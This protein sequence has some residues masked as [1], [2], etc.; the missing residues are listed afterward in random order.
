[1]TFSTDL[2]QKIAANSASF[3]NSCQF[4]PIGADI[5]NG[6]V[7]LATSA[8]ESRSWSYIHYLT[9]RPQ[10][11]TKGTV[12]Y[13][14]GDRQ[15]LVDRRWVGGENAYYKFGGI[16]RVTDDKLGKIQLGLQCLLSALAE[17]PH[18]NEW[19]LALVASVHDKATLGQ[20]IKEA[21][22]GAHTVLLAGR[23]SQV[24]IRVMGVLQEGAGAIYHYRRT[25][26]TKNV[27]VY[28]LGNGTI[29]VSQFSGLDLNHHNF[30]TEGGVERLIDKVAANKAVKRQLLQEGDRHLIRAGIE[31]K[32]FT[33][34]T[35]HPG[36]TFKEPFQEE[37]QRWVHEVLAPMNRHVE[38]A[39][40]SA[41]ALIAIG[42]GA[43]LDGIGTLLS[44]KGIQV[45]EDPQWANARGLYEMA[46][47]RL[48][49]ENR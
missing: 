7:K 22:Q 14:S 8:G 38:Q 27:L 28:D 5:G 39:R 25:I 24:N 23:P 30:S 1:M 37:L 26:E 33:Y 34:G 36:W 9:E 49:K 43:C 15:D 48:Q 19:N 32:T 13:V 29:I 2:D 11:G 47:Q 21:L 44:Q 41:T 16:H 3:A 46:L 31:D 18:R 42:G 6:A 40:S 20:G 17:L 35:Q 10:H 12:E 45:G 4:C